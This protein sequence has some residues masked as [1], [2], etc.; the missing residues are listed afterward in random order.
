MI[1]LNKPAKTKDGKIV[2]PFLV[3]DEVAY[4]Y[5]KN[6]N[7]KFF[8]LNELEEV[9]EEENSNNIIIVSPNNYNDQL[10]EEEPNIDVEEQKKDVISDENYI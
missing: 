1:R 5:D 8:N 7:T 6:N 4:C 10:F 3:E 2:V 9:K